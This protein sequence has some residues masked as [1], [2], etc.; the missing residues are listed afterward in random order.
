ME[1]HGTVRSLILPE[2][3]ERIAA[4]LSWSQEEALD[5]FYTS[6]V[7]QAYADNT[8]GLYGQSPLYIA[9]LFE[10]HVKP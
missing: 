5:R 8:T 6:K 7:G 3:I 10:Q 2:V 9:T 1:K 4:D